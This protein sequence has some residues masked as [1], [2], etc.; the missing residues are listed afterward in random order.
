MG[1]EVFKSS[2]EFDLALLDY[3]DPIRDE[4]SEVQV[5]LRNQNREA[6]ALETAI[7]SAALGAPILHYE[8]EERE[9]G[10]CK[11]TVIVGPEPK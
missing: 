11:F 6:L 1:L 10:T 8:L 7:R 2:L 4:L 5:L 3:I 9:D